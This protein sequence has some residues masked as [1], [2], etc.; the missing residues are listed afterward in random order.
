MSVPIIDGWGVEADGRPASMYYHWWA[1][2]SEAGQIDWDDP[3]LKELWG[4]SIISVHME[5]H[6]SPH[7]RTYLNMKRPHRHTPSI[8]EW[9]I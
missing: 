6:L 9:R 8:K 3:E 1:Y 7:S 4:K 2:H 5:D